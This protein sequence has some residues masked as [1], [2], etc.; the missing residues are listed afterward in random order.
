[1][2]SSWHHKH[3]D[4]VIIYYPKMQIFIWYRM[5]LCWHNHCIHSLLDGSQIISRK[6][7]VSLELVDMLMILMFYSFLS[8]MDSKLYFLIANNLDMLM[9]LMFYGFQVLF[10]DCK[11]LGIKRLAGSPNICIY[12]YLIMYYMYKYYLICIIRNNTSQIRNFIRIF[13][14]T[15]Y[16]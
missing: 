14:Y 9:I 10:S 7:L 11:Q 3:I 13:K 4:Q 12:I 6:W 2:L 16:F 15:Q 8:F 1:M 5:L